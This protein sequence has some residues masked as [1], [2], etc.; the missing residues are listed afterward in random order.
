MKRLILILAIIAGLTFIFIGCEKKVYVVEKDKTPP[1]SPKGVY[2]VTGDG[3]VY[4]YWE[5]SDEP[6]LS[7]YGIYWAPETDGIIPEP[8]GDFTFMTW[9]NS[10]SYIDT[11]VTNG[12]TYYYVITAVDYSG[13]ESE[14]SEILYDTPRPEG[15]NDTLFNLSVNPNHAGLYLHEELGPVVIAWNHS[16]CDI[17]LDKVSGIFYLNTTVKDNIPNDIQDFG[18]TD[19]L[20]EI[21]VAPTTDIGWSELGY[22]EVILN[23]TYVIWTWDNH[24]AKLRVTAIEND[25]IKFEWA[26]QIDAGNP[27]LKPVPKKVVN[28]N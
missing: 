20:D 12:N 15:Y 27:E 11:D 23:H 16:L 18:Y 26:Y 14:P 19:N 10:T 9:V 2:S 25:Y 24:Y 8:D 21:N 13:N 6:D 5:G 1:C 3:A 4:L 22:V 28:R 17:F 7:K